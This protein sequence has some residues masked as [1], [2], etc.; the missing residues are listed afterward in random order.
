MKTKTLLFGAALSVLMSSVAF[1]ADNNADAK[2]TTRGYV[3]GGLSF[4]YQKAADADTKAEA[5]DDRVDALVDV[6][7]T[8]ATTGLQGDVAD[9]KNKV[10]NLPAAKTYTGG[11]GI[12][13][14]PGQNDEPS[15]INLKLDN[16]TTGA[17]YVFQP[18]DNGGGSWVALS[19]ENT[20]DEAAVA[21]ITATQTE[22]ESGE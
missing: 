17:N 20:W 3:D 19:V 6:V 8:D 2:L 15:T 5:V 22:Q 13:V 21:R 10:N 18:A 16:P 4:V 12:T 9:L 7:G 11:T 14:T 1:A